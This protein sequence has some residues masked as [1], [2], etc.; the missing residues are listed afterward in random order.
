VG[1][2]AAGCN[3]LALQAAAPPFD[4]AVQVGSIISRSPGLARSIAAWMEADAATWVGAL[5]PMVTVTVSI[6][7]WPPAVVIAN[8]PQCAVEPPNMACCWI[9]H[10]GTLGGLRPVPTRFAVPVM[11]VSDQ[12]TF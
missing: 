9:A 11:V 5:P 2:P 3:E 10:S 12:L 4:T 1:T 6:D 7:A 8:S